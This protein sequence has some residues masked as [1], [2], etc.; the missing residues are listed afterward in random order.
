MQYTAGP[1]RE[2]IGPRLGSLEERHRSDTARGLEGGRQTPQE[3]ECTPGRWNSACKGV[4][5]RWQA[6][7]DQNVGVKWQ[8]MGLFVRLE[9]A[10]SLKRGFYS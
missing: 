8:E 10:K 7:C 3:E 6:L 4:E 9:Q 2:E 5:G 1:R